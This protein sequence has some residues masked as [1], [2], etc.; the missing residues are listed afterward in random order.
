MPEFT[1]YKVADISLADFGRK[2]ISLAEHE[3][4]GLM[5]LRE[6]FGA[7]QP[8]AGARIAGSLHMT[9]QTA[10]LIETL[11][12]L[13]AQVR[14]ASC[15]IF[16]TQ[17]HAAA[18]IAAAGI[19]VF[20]WK[21]ETLEEYWWCAEQ[22]LRWP[23]GEGPNLILDDG[24]DATLLVHKGVEFEKAGSVPDPS[25]ADNEEYA[26]VLSLLQRSF[27]EDA[28]RWTS[29]AN[30][31]KGV[32]EETTTGVHRLYQMME[33][34]S[35]LFPAINV[36]DSVTK[37]KFDNIYGCR[38]SVIDGINRATDVMIGGKVAVVCGF[39]EVGKGCAQALRGQGAR[40]IVTEI[41]PICALQAAMEG[42]EVNT[43]DEV[44]GYADI[45]VTATGNT[46]VITADH[47]SRM[48]HQ[49]IVGNIGHFDNEIDMAGLAK[50]PGVERKNIKPQCDEWVFPD[51]H[52]VIVLAEGRLLNLGCATGHPS[53]VMSTSFTNQVMAQIELHTN[54][55]Q[56][57][58]KVYVL[59]KQLD[60]KVARLHLDKLGVKLT[61]LTDRQSAYLGI[62]KE[63][64]FKPEQ[65]RY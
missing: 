29:I 53:F 28:N 43:L 7:D 18:A 13:G 3:M 24:G 57:E 15:N 21:G 27:G 1:D 46:D 58:N 20:A 35:L 32:S 2:E 10:V 34:G 5:A 50:V 61:E 40:V 26:V 45:F 55:E 25:T 63:G 41:D 11:V 17:D 36:N 42:Y 59:P 51:G 56:Y 4:P 47:M 14:W 23:N 62:P 6:E 30:G 16:S 31:I 22:I 8:L 48:K 37:S 44:V 39:G 60:E 12:A 38:H 64:P 65:Y 9:I 49:A 33:T 52:S 54:T 19:P